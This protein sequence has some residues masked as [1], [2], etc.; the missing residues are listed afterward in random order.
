MSSPE[1]HQVIDAVKG[2]W[3]SNP[4]TE[5]LSCAKLLA[6]VK[7][8]NPSWALSEKR[9][10]SI[11]KNQ[12]LQPTTQQPTFGTKVESHPV[13]NL[14]FPPGISM[15]VTKSKGKA[16]FSGT[17]YKQGDELWHEEVL[18]PVIPL[19]KVP[20]VHKAVACVL[21]ARTF[22]ARSKD[23][24]PEG[25]AECNQCSAKWC[26]MKC[27]NADLIHAAL[28]HHNPHSKINEK[29]WEKFEKFC[30]ENSWQSMYATG[31]ILISILKDTSS[32]KNHNL[33]DKIESMASIRQDEIDKI[34]AVEVDYS[35]PFEMLKECMRPS[36]ELEYDVFM[37]TLGIYKLN[38]YEGNLYSIASHVNHSCIPNI[39]IEFAIGKHHRSSS[40]IRVTALRYI[41][42]G[43]ELFFN[44]D[45]YSS[46]HEDDNDMSTRRSYLRNNYGFQCCCNKCKDEEKQLNDAAQATLDSGKDVLA[47]YA[48][49]QTK[50][51][52]RR[53]S[54][55]F[56]EQI[57]VA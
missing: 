4:A 28:W 13:N 51:R 54:V 45:N 21:C 20:L 5:V 50:L 36:T 55:K 53:K 9:L 22:Q 29:E 37:K 46:S 57:Q 31:V 30:F 34:L 27:H 43:E 16:L 56:D 33:K 3:D 2:I 38:S 25:H 11:L 48:D 42:Q 26:S 39:K 35:E 10:K 19:D 15:Q 17:S 47:L 49:I 18:L 32:T 6:L 44:Y 24:Q 40:S 12:G 41:N 52:S 8:R 1:E 7:L 14:E 23:G